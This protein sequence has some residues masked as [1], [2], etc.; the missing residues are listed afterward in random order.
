MQVPVA[1][2]ELSEGTDPAAKVRQ[3]L[4]REVRAD[5][6][7]PDVRSKCEAPL[8]R[9]R[10]A[11]P[12]ADDRVEEVL[13]ARG[14]SSRR[15]RRQSEVGL[16]IEVADAEDDIDGTLG[17]A[18]QQER[19]RFEQRLF[20]LVVQCGRPPNPPLCPR[21]I[22]QEASREAAKARR[23]REAP[24]SWDRPRYRARPG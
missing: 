2:I 10:P 9:Q 18:A 6:E 5:A 8:L 12:R 4:P 23:G 1:E 7:P 21:P 3:E 17:A 15:H 14:A 20:H 13:P 24:T 19:T 16:Q 11:P 22:E